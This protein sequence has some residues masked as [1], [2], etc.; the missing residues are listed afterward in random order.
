MFA[1]GVP[2]S[3]HY[4]GGAARDGNG[5]FWEI[6]GTIGDIRVSGSSGHT[7]MVQLS[8]EGARGDEKIFQQLEIP[9]SYRSG[10]PEDA[11]S[12]RRSPLCQDGQGS[13]RRHPQGAE[14]RGC[15]RR[16]SHHRR[17][18]KS[19]RNR[20]DDNRWMGQTVAGYCSLGWRATPDDD[21]HYVHAVAL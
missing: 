11:E 6:H 20:S 9:A 19:S 18:R 17:N 2:V 7:Q 5:L 8:I 1:S 15:P 3:I 14:L 21:E 12:E 16:A 4:R 10:W 13:A